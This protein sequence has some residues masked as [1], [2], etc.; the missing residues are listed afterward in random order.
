MVSHIA[1]L[2]AAHFAL[3]FP[4][5][6]LLDGLGLTLFD[7]FTILYNSRQHDFV[8]YAA[9]RVAFFH[10]FVAFYPCGECWNF[11]K[12]EKDNRILQNKITIS[13]K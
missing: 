13:D 10:A 11:F 3:V 4:P 12:S 2:T 6:E 9:K 5:E 8:E 1:I 7:L